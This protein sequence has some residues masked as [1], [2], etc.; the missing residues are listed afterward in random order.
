LAGLAAETAHLIGG[1]SGGRYTLRLPAADTL[2]QSFSSMPYIPYNIPIYY[3]HPIQQQTGD[4]RN[5]VAAV[6][7]RNNIIAL[8]A[9]SSATAYDAPD[10]YQRQIQ[11]RYRPGYKKGY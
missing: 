5:R 2:A 3:D 6:A 8:D 11:I 4:Y 1:Y 10:R 9:D 7:A